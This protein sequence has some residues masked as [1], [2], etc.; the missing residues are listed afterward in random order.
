MNN[1]M[2]LHIARVGAARKLA[3]PVPALQGAFQSGR[4]PTCFTTHVH[5]FALMVGAELNSAGIA[6]KSTAGLGTKAHAIF[7]F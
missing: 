6:G 4:E 7:Q 5:R 3:A 1:V 2:G